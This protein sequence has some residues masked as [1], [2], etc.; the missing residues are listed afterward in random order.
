MHRENSR[1]KL[2]RKIGQKKLQL[3]RKQKKRLLLKLPSY[4]KPMTRQVSRLP[5][6]KLKRKQKKRLK[7]WLRRRRSAMLKPA[8]LPSKMDNSRLRSKMPKSQST[9][10]HSVKWT[11]L[12]SLRWSTPKKHLSGKPKQMCTKEDI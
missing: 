1:L 10:T 11:L 4:K 9:L 7:K 8:A 5:L 2:S 3:L 12:L 6:P